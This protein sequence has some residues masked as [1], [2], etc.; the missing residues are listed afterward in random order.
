MSARGGAEARANPGLFGEEPETRLRAATDRRAA[1]ALALVPG[2][3]PVRYRELAE[4]ATAADLAFARLGDPAARAEALRGADDALARGA[5]AG[6]ALLLLGDPAYPASLL[7]LPDPPPALWTLGDRLLVA[8]PER[9]VA[10]VGTRA[11]TAYGQRVTLALAGALA[12]AGAVIVSGMARGVDAVA[13]EAALAEGGATVAVLGTGIDVPYPAA[14]RALHRQ[15]AR[16]GMVMSEAWPGTRATPGA[17]P[18]RNRIIAALARATLVT[19]A[20]VKSGALLT[21]GVALDLGRTVAAVPGPIDAAPSAGCNL[22]I[23]DGAVVVV[24]PADA[25]ALVGLATPGARPTAATS[26]GL[27]TPQPDALD[28]AGAAVWTAL[29]SPASDLE[30]LVRASGLPARRC[31]AALTALELSGRATVG[32]GGEIRRR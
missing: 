12:R 28:A 16:R 14:N 13:H 22:L 5:D 8:A 2:V 27:P 6:A 23:R 17:F 30:T 29:A 9:A 7:E 10:I 25:V 1:L 19:E 20:G 4:R 11:M 18:R 31:V 15:I 26:D 21:A 32:P 3:G 24:E